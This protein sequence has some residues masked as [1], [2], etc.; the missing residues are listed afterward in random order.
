MAVK[1]CED[2]LE[3]YEEQRI[4]DKK[5]VPNMLFKGTDS[6]IPAPAK[7]L[8]RLSESSEGSCQEC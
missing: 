8:K 3:Q 1:L 6:S 5:Q 4:Y 7:G 2:A